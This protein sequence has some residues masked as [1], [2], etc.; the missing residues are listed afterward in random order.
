ME[1]RTRWTRRSGALVFAGAL[2]LALG[3]WGCPGE[4]S[5][6]EGAAATEDAEASA[7]EDDGAGEATTAPAAT[8][9]AGVD[10]TTP[11]S[12]DTAEAGAQE[13]DAGEPAAGV[14]VSKG[15]EEFRL[16][17]I[18]VA[19]SG[20]GLWLAA[21]DLGGRVTLWNTKTE[22]LLIQDTLPE[23]NRVRTVGFARVAPVMVSGAFQAPDAPFRVWQMQPAGFRHTLGSMHFQ[24]RQ[25]VID[26]AGELLLGFM[27]VGNETNKIGVWGIDD[28]ELRLAAS[29]DGEGFV[30]MSGDGRTVAAAGQDGTLRVWRARA[31]AVVPAVPDGANPDAGSAPPVAKMELVATKRFESAATLQR[32]LLSKDGRAMWGAAGNQVFH[33]TLDGPPTLARTVTIGAPGGVIRGLELLPDGRAVAVTRPKKGGVRLWDVDDGHLRVDAQ[34]GCRCEAYALSGDGKS[35]ACDCVPEAS[36]RLWRLPDGA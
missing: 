23:G 29:H 4:S 35:L 5:E 25:L 12:S 11:T 31:D 9:A 28:G 3:A 8:T 34:S 14:T 33:Y 6:G 22:R 20:D 19:L 18:C 36:I 1:L 21:G 2:A 17:G 13:A 27:D 32:L 10:A 16:D 26:D 15:Y 30:S 24:A 7:P